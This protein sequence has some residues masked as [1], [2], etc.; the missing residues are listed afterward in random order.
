MPLQSTYAKVKGCNNMFNIPEV[1]DI[2]DAN[3]THIYLYYTL[4]NKK[5]LCVL[6]YVLLYVFGLIV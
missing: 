2:I 6:I 1:C 4:F 3:C 5:S